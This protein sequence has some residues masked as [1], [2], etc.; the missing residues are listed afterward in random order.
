MSDD[1][2]HKAPDSQRTPLLA[3]VLHRHRPPEVGNLNMKSLWYT[4][5]RSTDI[6][7]KQRLDELV[8]RIDRA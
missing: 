1:V 4:C 5:T 6:T 7:I 8:I 3:R 2:G